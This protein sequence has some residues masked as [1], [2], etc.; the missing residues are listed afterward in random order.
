MIQSSKSKIEYGDFQTPLELAEKICSKLNEL[1]IDPDVIIEPTCGIG[2]FINASYRFFK[3]ARE[4]IGIEINSGYI[5]EAKNNF[6]IDGENKISI[7][8]TDFFI[9]NW[10]SYI[11]K[12]D[13]DNILIIGNFPWVTNARQGTIEGN[14]L[15]YKENFQN[16]KGLEAITG[17]SNFDISEWMLIQMVK[18]LHERRACIAMLCKT[19]VARKILNYIHSQNLNLQQCSIYK[20]DAKKYFNASVEACLLFCAFDKNSKNYFCDVFESLEAKQSYRIGYYNKNLLKNVITFQNIKD[21]YTQNLEYQWRSGVKHDRSDVMEFK[22]VERGFI[23]GFGECIDLEETY[24]YP[25]LKGS[26]VARGRIETTDRYV[27]LTQQKVGEPTDKI[28]ASAPKTWNYLNRYASYLDSRKSKIYLNNP[29]FSIF[30]VGDYTFYPWKIAICGLY[31][32]LE[33]VL[34]GELNNKSV[35][36]DDTVYFLAFQ[37]EITTRKTFAMLNSDLAKRFYDSLIFWD[38]KRPIKTRILNCLNLS[39][40]AD[41][42][43]IDR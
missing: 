17:S 34:I 10:D 24:L 31:K 9:F 14:N 5:Q 26:D 16:H 35:I 38:D 39:T 41:R 1:D 3:L 22:K 7:Y 18:L 4:I 6:Q 27:L 42:L 43:A 13:S 25:L 20:I 12:L 19:S 11:K 29:R 8:Q 36:F 33:F 30:G 2:N 15:P 28:Q 32:K 40:L 21:L 23:N 37:D